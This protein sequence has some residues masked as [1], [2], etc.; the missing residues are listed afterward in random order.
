MTA[1]L[2]RGQMKA[3]AAVTLV[4]ALM[5]LGLL[6]AV[7][8]PTAI[9]EIEGNTT[10]TFTQDNGTTVEIN[11]KLNSTVTDADTSGSTHNATIELN[12]TRTAGTTTKTIDNGSTAD[13]ALDGGTVTVG[14]EDVTTSSNPD[15]VTANYT[16][17]NDYSFSDSSRSL[18][19]T[20]GMIL[21]LA[22]FLF[23]V[24]VGLRVYRGLAG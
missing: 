7:M 3:G 12:D 1:K 18:W 19:G 13:Y 14:V 20:L 5:V 2:D 16:Y 15:T 23:V 24:G 21:V 6:A 22:V 9:D 17:S 8:L 10:A 4:V 11:A